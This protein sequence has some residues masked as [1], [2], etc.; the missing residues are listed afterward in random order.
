[1]I[2]FDE[3]K[4]INLFKDLNTNLN[5]SVDKILGL[6]HVKGKDHTAI[7]EILEDPVVKVVTPV[8]LIEL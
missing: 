4:G 6:L 2:I 7:N 1:M 5:L 3:Y 8:T